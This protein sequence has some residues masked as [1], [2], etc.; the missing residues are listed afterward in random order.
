MMLTASTP[1][2]LSTSI[3]SEM[4]SRKPARFSNSSI[5][6]TSSLRFSRRPAASALLSFCHISV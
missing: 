1:S 4:C 6:R 3:T 2:A 5:E